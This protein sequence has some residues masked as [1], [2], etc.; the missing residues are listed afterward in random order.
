MSLENDDLQFGFKKNSS[1][2]ICTSTLKDT[3]DYYKEHKT[4]VINYSIDC[5]T[6]ICVQLIN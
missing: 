5:V 3:I 4:D 2:V 1:T 6:G